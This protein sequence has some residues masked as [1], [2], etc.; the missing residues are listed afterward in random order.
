M[1]KLTQ[2]SLAIDSSE[3]EKAERL[4]ISIN[5]KIK[6]YNKEVAKSNRLLRE[7]EELRRK[8]NISVKHGKTLG[9]VEKPNVQSK[10]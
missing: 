2:L 4:L 9:L 10:L 1:Q 6:E 7:Q 8:L 3:I 5:K